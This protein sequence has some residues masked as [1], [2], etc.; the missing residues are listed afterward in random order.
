MEMKK[1]PLPAPAFHKEYTLPRAQEYL[2]RH[3]SQ[4][5]PLSK[6]DYSKKDPTGEMEK[7]KKAPLPT[8][9]FHK[10][11]PLPRAERSPDRRYS[12]YPPPSMDGC[13]G[14]NAGSWP[15]HLTYY[16]PPSDLHVDWRNKDGVVDMEH[17]ST[18]LFAAMDKVGTTTGYG[19]RDGSIEVPVREVAALKISDN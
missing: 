13:S 7:K 17:Y 18:E 6:D 3:Y 1:A 2:D 9:H 14:K 5:P 11:R 10:E 4:R 12:P 16:G 15:L 19:Q 8:P